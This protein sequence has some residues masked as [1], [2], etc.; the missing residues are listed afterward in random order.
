MKKPQAKKW[1]VYPRLPAEI[2]AQLADYPPIFRQVLFNRGIEDECQADRFL[3][4]SGEI[5]DPFLMK[6][7]AI[8]VD[9]IIRAVRE[10]KSILVFGDYDADGVTATALL[11]Q[12]LRF[13]GARVDKYIPNRFEE[14]Y[15]FSM[16][17]LEGV[18]QQKPDMLITVDCGVRSVEEVALANRQ[19]I[20]VII[21]DHHQPLGNILPEA[22]AI[23]CSRQPDDEY[24]YACLAGVGIAYKLVQ[25]LQISLPETGLDADHWLDL[26]AIGTVADL[27][28][29]TDENRILTKR[30]IEQIRWG[31]HAGISAL[32]AISKIEDLSSFNAGHIGFMIGPRLNAAGR[33][34]TA[35]AAYQLLM[36]SNEGEASA[37]ADQLN[38]ENQA[39]QTATN[40]IFSMVEEHF[41]E[42]EEEWL[43]F[44]AHEEFNEGIVGLAASRLA[45]RYYRPAIIG[46]ISGDTIRASCRSISELDITQSLD[47]CADLLE[48]HGGHAMAAGLTI[49]SENLEEFSKRLSSVI[50]E[51]L[52]GKE[53]V[54]VLKAEMEVGL[55][56]LNPVLIPLLES[57]DPCGEQNPTPLFI[58]LNVE[59]TAIR[60][61]GI[62][63]DHIRLDVRS[64]KDEQNSQKITYSGIGFNLGWM[65]EQLE[66]GSVIDI[67]YSFE[68]NEFNGRK[69]PQLNIRDIKTAG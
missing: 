26:V 60:T 17:A 57:L 67:L 51:E 24:P 45:E 27:A 12:A 50:A 28:P 69:T 7:M 14:G 49:Q 53:L 23:I 32:A 29:L 61:L 41:L 31:E 35:E 48:K 19:G 34:S 59:I 6:D 8:A 55:S 58:S 11:V 1:E 56:N 54:P 62:S 39:R 64:R 25:A 46:S 3:F 63:K 15:G 13:L 66:A 16:N 65:A 22:A 4:A 42:R 37:L 38:R 36:T 2:E 30:G 43:L 9:R 5:H 20:E 33:L 40:E 68:N 52:A 21:T 44:Y 10:G 18:L 47:Q